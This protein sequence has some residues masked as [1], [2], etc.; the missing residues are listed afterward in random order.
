MGIAC[1]MSKLRTPGHTDSLLVADW[2]PIRRAVAGVEYLHTLLILGYKCFR[3]G[4]EIAKE[5]GYGHS[6]RTPAA[7]RQDRNP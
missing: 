6:S 7:H 1:V 3:D 5:I 2:Q 4:K